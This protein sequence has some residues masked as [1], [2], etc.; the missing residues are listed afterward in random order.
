MPAHSS[1]REY[2]LLTSLMDSIL[3]FNSSSTVTELGG[4]DVEMV[5]IFDVAGLFCGGDVF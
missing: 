2:S 1:G 4:V 5:E 3:S